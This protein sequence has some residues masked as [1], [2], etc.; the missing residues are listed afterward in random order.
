MR[1]TLTR[2]IQNLEQ[3]G[4]SAVSRH[5]CIPPRERAALLRPNDAECSGPVRYGDDPWSVEVYPNRGGR[6]RVL[7]FDHGLRYKV[8]TGQE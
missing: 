6:K 8:N 2:S 7:P 4:L 5:A 1:F 3:A